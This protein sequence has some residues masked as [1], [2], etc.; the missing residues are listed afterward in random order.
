MIDILR[1]LLPTAKQGLH[2]LGVDEQEIAEQLS[3]IKGGLDS[4]MN[5]ATWQLNRFNHYLK[6]QTRELALAMMVEDYY[7]EYK[8]GKAVHEWSDGL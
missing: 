2:L 5:G 4:Q 1:N 7:R 6:N 8:T 3:V